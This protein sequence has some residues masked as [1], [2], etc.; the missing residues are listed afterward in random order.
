V[1]EP[2]TNIACGTG[3]NMEGKQAGTGRWSPDGSRL[4]CPVC[5]QILAGL[6]RCPNHWC[7]RNDRA[8]SVAFSVGIHEGALRHAV[9]RYKYRDELWWAGVF[10]RLLADH[11][12]GHSTWF[13]EFDLLVPT[14]SYVGPS[15]RRSWDPVGEIA[16]R[17]C[18]LV[19]PLWEVALGAVRKKRETP[20]MQ[21]RGWADRRAIAAG[22][23]RRSLVVPAPGLVAGAR[24]LVLDDVLTDGSTLR[25][26][27]RV[28]RRA[29]AR[30]VAG[31]VLARPCWR[32]RPLI[33]DYES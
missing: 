30:E 17:L 3:G 11:L 12:R 22:P 19:E 15:A 2:S 13:E 23:L 1:L 21:G 24:I 31:L 20:P 29:G 33:P 27:A 18:R 14:P 28:L 32:D 6:E 5:G 10:A 7:H 16:S 4:G 25:E 9:L 26:V 8:F